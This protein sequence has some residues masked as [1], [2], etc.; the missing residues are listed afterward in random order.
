[1]Y[2]PRDPS[3]TSETFHYKRGAN[4]LFSQSSHIFDPSKNSDEELSY[5][6]EKEVVPIAIH[7]VAEEGLDGNLMIIDWCIRK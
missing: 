6:L 2:T 3:L 1:M 7:C 4:Q 5:D